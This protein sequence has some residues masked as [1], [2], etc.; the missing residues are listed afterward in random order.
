MQ[1]KRQGAQFIKFLE[2]P[3]MSRGVQSF[4][5]NE[6]RRALRATMAEG[7]DVKRVTIGKGGQIE[8]EIGK[9][10]EA[11]APAGY[12]NEWDTVG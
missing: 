11:A 5:Q 7:F 3:R 9:P 2:Q 6:I 8:I 1:N 12:A 10:A 4:R